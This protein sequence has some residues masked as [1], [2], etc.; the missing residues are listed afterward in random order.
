VQR[1]DWTL[2]NVAGITLGLAITSIGQAADV[3]PAVSGQSGVISMPDANVEDDGVWRV[4]VSRF[5]PY[6]TYWTSITALPR[7]ELSGRYTAITGVPAWSEK[8]Y[9]DYKDKAFDVKWQLVRESSRVPRVALG[10]QDFLG[11]KKFAGQYAVLSKRIG[12]ADL[13]AGVGRKRID[14]PFAGLRYRLN[15]RW[16]VLAEYDAI[17]YANDFDAALSGAD[18]RRGGLSYGAEYNYGWLGANVSRQSN[19][20][21]INVFVKIPLMEKSFVPRLAE[22]PPDFTPPQGG[23]ASTWAQQQGLALEK[24][25]EQQGYKN[26]QL[27]LDGDAIS[28]TAAH[29]RI[30]LPGRVAGRA[31]RTMEH[32]APYNITELDFYLLER[33]MPLLSYHV[34]S[35]EEMARYFGGGRPLATLEPYITYSQPSRRDMARR[36]V[37]SLETTPPTDGRAEIAVGDSEGYA[38][39][40]RSEDSDSNHWSIAP[41]NLSFF[42]NDPS[43]A[44]HYELFVSGTVQRRL[45]SSLYMRGSATLT[46]LEDVSSVT[47]PSNSLLPHVRSDVAEYKRE[48]PLKLTDLL[49]NKYFFIDSGVYGRASIGLYE[50]MF[51]GFG[52][53]ILYLPIDKRWGVDISVDLLQQRAYEGGFAFQDYRVLST[54]IAAHYRIP[55]VDVT[56]TVRAG[57]FLAKDEGARFELKRRYKSGFEFGL[58][59]TVT[60]GQ[61]ITSPGRPSS[62]YYDKGLFMTIPLNSMLTADTRQA[63]RLSL[64]PWT[65]DVGQIV[66]SPDDLYELVEKRLNLGDSDSTPLSEFGY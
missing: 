58:W 38:V 55:V 62:P 22:P 57:R 39:I 16:N 28:G 9:G 6:M 36:G 54:L 66:H 53:Q 13:S 12:A 2:Y 33:D 51:G 63:P 3:N 43:G 4:G 30:S 46:L 7:L 45:A 23:E 50:E 52:G 25:L 11:T 26:V 21:G 56:A 42:F 18:K 47:Q 37:T 35:R 41:L 59:Y 20:T 49:L 10:L 48:G 27:S 40:V 15:D 14:G 44:V 61:D 19:H 1:R 65:R 60:N 34:Q 29:D 64:S 32:Y 24:N 5:S 17:D 8:N 31:L